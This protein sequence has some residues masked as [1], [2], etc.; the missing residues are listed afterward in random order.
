MHIQNITY[1][2]GLVTGYSLC[3]NNTTSCT[4]LFYSDGILKAFLV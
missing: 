1:R 4:E 3:L 2:S